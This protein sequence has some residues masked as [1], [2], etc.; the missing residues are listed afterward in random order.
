MRVRSQ[1]WR[2]SSQDSIVRRRK[3]WA[4]VRPVALLAVGLSAATG[5]ATDHSSLTVNSDPRT[6]EQIFPEV[7]PLVANL[8]TSTEGGPCGEVIWSKT[9]PANFAPIAGAAPGNSAIELG[10]EISL[11]GP[12]G[13]RDLCRVSV[14][15]QEGAAGYEAVEGTPFDLTCTIWDVCPALNGVAG[16]CGTNGAVVLGTATTA[17]VVIPTGTAQ[18]VDINFNPPLMNVPENIVVMFR[19]N[20]AGPAIQ[21]GGNAPII[22]TLPTSRFIRCGSATTNNGCDRNFGVNNALAFTVSAQ[23][24]PAIGSCCDRGSGVCL[25]GVTAAECT[26]AMQVFSAGVSCSDPGACVAAMGA[27]CI[28]VDP[29]CVDGQTIAACAELGGTFAG[30]GTT[31]LDAGCAPTCQP[32]G[33]GQLIDF[34]GHG[35]GGTLAAT[36]DENPAFG[37]SAADNFSPLQTGTLTSVRWWGIYHDFSGSPGGA[38]NSVGGDSTDS[39][40]LTVRIDVG[41]AP[42]APAAGPIPV[43]PVATPTGIQVLA[44]EVFQYSVSG[45]NI[46]VDVGYCYWLEIV[47]HTTGNCAWLWST[48]PEG[49]LRSAQAVGGFP[50]GSVSD[51]DFD[52]SWCLDI[53]VAPS[54]CDAC[55]DLDHDDDVDANDFSLFLIAMGH[56]AGDAEF[57][58]GADLDHDGVVT[59]VDYQLWLACYRN[60]IGDPHI[61][62]PIPSDA[63]DMN[64]D[65][66]ID[67][68]DIQAFVSTLLSPEA[69]GFRQRFV[70]DIN[71]DGA[72]DAADAQALTTLLLP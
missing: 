21:V 64:A 55:G 47:N 32:G 31:C 48:G 20:R 52:L 53:Q 50:N 66:N 45:L 62:A 7:A 27:C 14:L 1:E 5:Y 39:F 54:A 9:L 28:P 41:G 61:S 2:Q 40:S 37:F 60:F 58:P 25:D 67:G 59:L 44:H 15:I 63:G 6:V 46:P 33:S 71:G 43:V 65:G 3:G 4:L 13:A 11:A 69:P 29:A 56:S 26:G 42:G 18:T 36:S 34:L 16:A 38:C 19:A 70:S 10:N 23:A 57:L 49:D 35:A 30:E 68:M 12:A 24:S 51:N 17:N 22:G 72:L 8:P